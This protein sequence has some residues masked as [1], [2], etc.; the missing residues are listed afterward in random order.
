MIPRS[1]RTS[2]ICS[3]P[4]F[5]PLYPFRHI[6]LI[7]SNVLPYF[8][9]GNAILGPL[10]AVAVKPTLRHLEQVRYFLDRQQARVAVLFHAQA[11][12]LSVGTI[13]RN[14]E[15]RLLPTQAVRFSI[16]RPLRRFSR[17]L[18]PYCA[19]PRAR[20]SGSRTHWFGLS[21]RKS[22]IFRCW[23]VRLNCSYQRQKDSRLCMCKAKAAGCVAATNTTPFPLSLC[24]DRGQK[25]QRHL[26]ACRLRQSD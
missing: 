12:L 17:I 18:A 4:S 13:T 16:T 22:A 6:I 1:V 5:V 14:Q 9:G 11:A 8:H 7:K 19:I 23:C 24:E 10:P 15:Y 21:K 26:E 20:I 3:H 25:F 2:S